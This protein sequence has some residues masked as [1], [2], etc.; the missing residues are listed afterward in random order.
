MQILRVDTDEIKYVSQANNL[1]IVFN[2]TL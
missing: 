2:S 1:G